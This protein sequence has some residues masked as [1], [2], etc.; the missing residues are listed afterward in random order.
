MSV[1]E[2]IYNLIIL[3]AE[4]PARANDFM[5]EASAVAKKF[6]VTVPRYPDIARLTPPPRTL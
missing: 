4:Q 1:S 6:K 3:A 5:Q 2:T